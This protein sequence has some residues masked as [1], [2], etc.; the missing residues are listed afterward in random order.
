MKQVQ[1]LYVL[2]CSRLL[3]WEIKVNGRTFASGMVEAKC[4]YGGEFK[5]QGGRNLRFQADIFCVG[6]VWRQTNRVIKICQGSLAAHFSHWMQGT[7]P[8]GKI[9]LKYDKIYPSN[10]TVFQFCI[11]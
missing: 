7:I 11:I 4:G 6:Q 1:I 3:K 9:H 8:Q 10:F 2:L 5:V